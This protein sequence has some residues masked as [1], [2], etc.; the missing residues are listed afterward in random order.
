MIAWW[1]WLLIWAGLVLGML[2]MLGASAWWLFHKSLVLLDDLGDLASRTEL[3][4]VD[5]TE[6]VRPPIAVLSGIG[7]VR[8]RE[9]ARRD[10]RAEVREA[11][12]E[13]RLQRARQITRLD[14]SRQRW[15]AAWYPA[16]PKGPG[17][18]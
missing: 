14:A 3:L 5:D 16:K 11:A 6:H 17:V 7:D 8:A 2:A 9:H 12:R 13:R 1:G 4:A 10:H 15:P 18:H